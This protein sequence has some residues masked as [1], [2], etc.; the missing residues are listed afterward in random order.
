V[1]CPAGFGHLFGDVP[2]IADTAL[3]PM[4]GDD[5]NPRRYAGVS[6]KHNQFAAFVTDT[7][8][9]QVSGGLWPSAKK[10]AIARDRL[11]LYLGLD[12]PLNLPRTSVKRGAASPDQL[13]R[14]A[15][16]LRRRLNTASSRKVSPYFGVFQIPGR[17]CWFAQVRLNGR[18]VQLGSFADDAQAAQIR[19]RVVLY[20]R[21]Q[22]EERWTPLNFPDARLSP[23]SIDDARRE[24]RRALKTET[25]SRYRG[26]FR[27]PGNPIHPWVASISPAKESL[28][29]GAYPTERQAALAYDRAALH[30]F[31][32]DAE[33]NFPKLRSKLRP[34]DVRVLQA[35]A[36]KQYKATTKSRFRGVYP[37]AGRW[38]ATIYE[39]KQQRYLGMFDTE[40]EAAEAYDRAAL[41][42]RRTRLRLNFDPV[43]GEELCGALVDLPARSKQR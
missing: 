1:G 28:Y 32:T 41:R 37:R 38:S 27:D 5:N 6:A 43:T 42:Q 24:S 26:V 33:L 7:R 9:R 25:T 13:R 31:G 15:R 19:D 3:D 4:S 29:L 17:Q 34:A 2:H 18:N 39:S 23:L 14:E 40:E 10:A 36:Y 16:I 20:L 30:Y 22:A 35:E 21:G 8:R 11:I 12:Q